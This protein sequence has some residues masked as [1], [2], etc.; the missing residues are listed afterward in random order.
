M[1]VLLEKGSELEREVVLLAQQQ[2]EKKH[3]QLKVRIVKNEVLKMSRRKKHVTDAATLISR[4]I[5]EQCL[6]ISVASNLFKVNDFVA[7][8]PHVEYAGGEDT[9]RKEKEKER[10]QGKEKGKGGS[11]LGFDFKPLHM[12]ESINDRGNPLS[13][14]DHSRR[15]REMERERERGRGWDA[16]GTEMP[17]NEHTGD[18]TNTDIDP[19]PDLDLDLDLD[20]ESVWC[21]RH[22]DKAERAKQ[23]SSRMKKYLTK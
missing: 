9:M 16:S 4:R 15:E 20:L 22:I 3:L 2:A 18:K 8:Q 14:T 11:G 21:T 5:I 6:Q 10:V 12:R 19:D 1:S 23:F 13:T 7:L 17:S